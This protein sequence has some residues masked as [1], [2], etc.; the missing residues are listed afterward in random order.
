MVIGANIKIFTSVLM[1]TDVIG[2]K[3]TIVFTADKI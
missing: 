1:A 3:K 2:L